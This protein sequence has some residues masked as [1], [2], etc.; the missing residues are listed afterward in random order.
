MISLCIQESL[1]GARQR[2]P[3]T[4]ASPSLS[5]SA[6]LVLLQYPC[7]SGSHSY[8]IVHN[9]HSFM[10]NLTRV[11]TE[12]RRPPETGRDASRPV[13]VPLDGQAKRA[14]PPRSYFGRA[15]PTSRPKWLR[16]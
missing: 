9:G 7:H 12:Q 16:A 5:P 15:L 3:S 11:R 10:T 13:L 8:S 1:E 4:S 2:L 6:S 14:E